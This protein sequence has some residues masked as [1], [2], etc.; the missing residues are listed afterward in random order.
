M[1]KLF[2]DNEG[3]RHDANMHDQPRPQAP[4]KL[5]TTASSFTNSDISLDLFFPL[6]VGCGVPSEVNIDRFFAKCT[7]PNISL[8]QVR[9][10]GLRSQQKRI[11]SFSEI[12]FDVSRK[13]LLVQFTTGPLS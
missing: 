12:N 6:L 11:H 5:I 2:D 4:L 9:R 13:A 7:R 10:A 1:L 3:M 8:S